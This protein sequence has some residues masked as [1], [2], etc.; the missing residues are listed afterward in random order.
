MKSQNKHVTWGAAASAF[1]I[2]G[3]CRADGKGPSVWD[4]YC[5]TPG[6][7]INGDTGDI[8]CDHYHRFEE[9]VALMK[10]LG[11]HAYRLSVSWP[12]ILPDGTG[13]VNAQGLDFYRRLVDTLCAAGIE[14]WIT[15]N[16]W[17]FPQALS[18]RGGWQNRE[19]MHWF[20]DYS[21][22]VVDALSDRVSHWMTHNEPQ[23]FIGMALQD[24]MHAPGLK[25]P[26][27]S[28]LQAGHHALLAH[29]R[30][31]QAIRAAART[32]PQIGIVSAAFS[33]VPAE[34]TPDNISAA[35]HMF[36]RVPHNSLLTNTW[37]LDPVCLGRYP[38]ETAAVYGDNMPDIHPGDMETIRQPLDF[39]GLNMYT[40]VR[41][42]ADVNGRPESVPPFPGTPRMTLNSWHSEPTLMYW[43][44]KWTYQRYGLPIVITE[45]GYADYDT[46]AADGCI[47]DSARITWIGAHL[48]E[49]NR[50][51]QSGIPID[52]YF[53][54]SIMDN[55]EWC[56]GYTERMGLIYVDYE[57]LA[58]RPK[59]SY[60]WYRNIINDNFMVKYKYKTDVRS[61]T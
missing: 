26:V 8:A 39:L 54:W 17:D 41:I 53:Y 24:G 36:E 42:R 48:S 7:I 30:S 35:R 9:D 47:H 51:I 31:V 37:W 56:H 52:G 57:T 15:L 50:A 10:N 55:F 23:C 25:L 4:E 49:L 34:D 60:F 18:M 5:H 61:M 40:A 59:D 11:L 12:R 58:R 19:S 44:P 14:P 1:Q 33:Y 3:G 43:S 46:P 45:N 28:V 27:T 13:T 21:T 6:T 22:V 32:P 29:G 20:A 38:E 16:H 2:E